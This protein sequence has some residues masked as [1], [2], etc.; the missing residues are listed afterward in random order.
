MCNNNSINTLSMDWS[1]EAS[2]EDLKYFYENSILSSVLKGDHC[3]ILGR[4]GSGKSALY[5]KIK[6]MAKNDF[7][8]E[9]VKMSEITISNYPE[10]NDDPLAL[11]KYLIY[12][13]VFKKLLY[14][15]SIII[16]NRAQLKE[17]FPESEELDTQVSKWTL[18]E[19]VISLINLT[20]FTF[21]KTESGKFSIGKKAAIISQIVLNICDKSPYYILFDELD[22]N[23]KSVSNL[24]PENKYH[25][26][27]L[28]LIRAT[29][30]VYTSAKERGLKIF[31]IVF[32]RDDIFNKIRSTD[33]AKYYEKARFITWDA[34]SLKELLVYRLNQNSGQHGKDF[35][36]AMESIFDAN[37]NQDEIFNT[38][39]LM[40][41]YRPRDIIRF[42]K[43]C[44]QSAIDNQA[45]KITF[46]IMLKAESLYVS[47]IQRDLM[48][49]YFTVIS[50]FDHVKSLLKQ[51]KYYFNWRYFETFFEDYQKNFHYFPGDSAMEL[52]EILFNSSMVGFES[53]KDK[54]TIFK[55]MDKDVSLDPT[56]TF[57]VHPVIRK[58][59][60]NMYSYVNERKDYITTFN[61]WF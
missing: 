21:K 45:D 9:G 58:Y 3:F 42:V 57:V 35:K 1:I 6:S 14:N 31:P 34:N 5:M 18:D 23:Y 49:E 22:L 55:Y 39:L 56:E 7:Y 50:R 4:K 15:E 46:D 61:P 8:V 52:L 51:T 53:I 59:V 20:Q 60:D 48:D 27:L 28:G 10:V 47:G 19:F 16:E 41:H 17:L 13:K 40:S 30:E 44:C 38:M 12:L 26:R 2:E 37:L 43:S 32:M 11:F 24:K 54:K 36:L 25:E 29:Y 33:K